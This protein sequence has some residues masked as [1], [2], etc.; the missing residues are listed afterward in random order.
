MDN[1]INEFEEEL[2]ENVIAIDTEGD[3]DIDETEDAFSEE[4]QRIKELGRAQQEFKHGYKMQTRKHSIV[5]ALSALLMIGATLYVLFA[6]ILAVRP[7]YGDGMEP[8]IQ[9]GHYVVVNKLAYYFR[10]PS[11]G[12]IITTDTNVYRI[13][14][15]PGDT[16]T[17][18]GGH[19]YINSELVTEEY[20]YQND[21]T[22]PIAGKEEFVVPEYSYFVLCDNRDCY[23][24]SR[25]GF[26]ILFYDIQGRVLFVI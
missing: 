20:N 10:S 1:K 14:G 26:T 11:R 12:D 2:D 25:Q 3:Q 19:L 9:N 6:V 22:C 8:T 17:F 4:D 23:D 7:V 5:S 21:L 24:D 16:V 15:L 18:E 13:V